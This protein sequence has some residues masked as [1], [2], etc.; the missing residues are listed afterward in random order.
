MLKIEGP[1]TV[2]AINQAMEEENDDRDKGLNSCDN[3][4]YEVAGDLA[5]PLFEFIKNHRESITLSVGGPK[6]P[7]CF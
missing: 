3:Q 7:R 2:E 1:I 4:Y 6:Y 5:G